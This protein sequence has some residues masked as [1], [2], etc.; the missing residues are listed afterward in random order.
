MKFIHYPLHLLQKLTVRYKQLKKHPLVG[1]PIFG[2]IR[3]ISINIFLRFKT[4]PI[5]WNWVNGIKYYLSIGD[6]CL[7][8]NCYFYIDDYEEISFLINYLDKNETFVDIGS[9]HGNYTLISSCIVGC[10]T[11]SV[12]PIQ[13]TFYRLNMNLKL[14]NVENVILKQIGIAERDGKLM[15]SNTVGELNK[16]IHDIDNESVE[17]VNVITL[18]KLLCKEM[19]VS[20]IKIDV[21]GFEKQVLLGGIKTLQKKQLDV[22][23]IEL[24]NS[25]NHYGYDEN[26]TI[27][28]LKS[29]GF[30]PYQYIPSKNYLMK[31]VGKNT[32][33]RDTLFIRD[34]KRVKNRLNKKTVKI[35]RNKVS[36]E[37]C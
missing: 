16:V 9:N 11:I 3:Y 27:S 17:A 19:N 23:Q 22:I 35:S 15:F 4:K 33:R 29:Y 1:N 7:I 34:I 28:I 13:S 20:M 6:S 10:K 30:K 24:N 37:Y 25:N 8:S 21:E 26:E 12:E 32:E 18:D 2:I 5:I 36:I 31:L 14:N